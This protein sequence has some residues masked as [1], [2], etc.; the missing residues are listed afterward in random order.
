MEKWSGLLKLI[1]VCCLVTTQSKAEV[2]F[3][4]D[5]APVL[6]NYC[7]ACHNDEDLEAE[8]SVETF[9]ALKQG[10]ESEKKM[11]VPGQPDQSYLIQVLTGDAKPKMPP[12]RETQLEEAHIALL[13]KWI[14]EGAKGPERS[15]DQSILKALTLPPIKPLK[16]V[17]PAITAAEISHDG[18]W[19]ARG[20]F[21]FVSVSSLPDVQRRWKTDEI[22]GKVSAVHIR[23]NRVIVASGVSGLRGEASVWDLETGDLIRRFD[24]GHDDLLYDADVSPDGTVLATAG[25]D[26]IIRFWNLESGEAISHIDG[27]YGA[28]FDLA[29]HPSGKLIASASADQTIKIWRMADGVRMDTL[30]QP[31]GEQFK[32]AFTP[33]GNY[34]LGVGADRRIRMWEQAGVD[35]PFLHPI[36]YTRFAH[37]GAIVDMTVSRDGKKLMT[38][39]ADRSIKLWSL[40]DLEPLHAW[41]S[42]QDVAQGLAI[43]NSAETFYVHFMNGESDFRELPN[44]ERSKKSS[45]TNE[46]AGNSTPDAVEQSTKEDWEVVQSQGTN[47]A[48]STAQKV[49]V[50]VVVEGRL[51]EP[52]KDAHFQFHAIQGQTWVVEVDAARSGSPLDSSIEILSAEGKAVERVRLQALRDSWFTFRGKDS[53]TSSDFRLQNWREMEL[54]EYLYANGE[55]SRLW[56]YPRGPD[57]GFLVYPGFGERQTYFG[58]SAITHALGELCYIVRPVPTGTEPAPNGLPVF[59]VYFQNDDDPA[60]RLGKDSKLIFNV[61]ETG[62]YIVRLSDVRGFGGE[63]YR[64]GLTIRPLKPGFTARVEGWPKDIS[65]GSGR[66][67]TIRVDRHDNFQGPIKIETTQLPEGYR[68]S[69]PIVVE[70][71]QYRA[72]GTVYLNDT[73]D[74]EEAIPEG[75]IRF[76]ASASVAG[77]KVEQELDFVG[78]VKAGPPAKISVKVLPL[79]EAEEAD[80]PLEL[81]IAPGETISARVRVQRNEFDARIPFGNEDA[82]RNLP[83]GL[84]VDNI[85]L[86]GLMIVE[87]QTEREF[88]ITAA[89]WVPETTR[90]FHLRTTADGGQC[91][92]PVVLHVRPSE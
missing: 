3:G 52:G 60:R 28:V 92:Q 86:N 33:D 78:K 24:K 16:D 56:L 38:T 72:F 62:T 64:Y 53:N 4:S 1:A 18:K 8:F 71:E 22:P 66:E 55:V 54:N 63:D 45:Q 88:F 80:D 91:S 7:A 2:S 70:A 83:H 79:N 48:W 34:I 36:K 46:H 32:V 29:F 44:M 9:R 67:F 59:P 81:T 73:K 31:Q 10:G 5:V 76:K 65:P 42:E 27:H 84:Y 58:T 51:N 77:A 17:V 13:S 85:G 75:E 89:K 43:S 25:Y 19:L 50:P 21:G 82:G 23:G 90:V 61:P 49:D 35:T 87:G 30:N 40:P 57:S 12:K 47:Q 41:E 74:K 6:R 68:I 11:I 37:E 26:R 15:E 69:T 39:S 14:E 20:G